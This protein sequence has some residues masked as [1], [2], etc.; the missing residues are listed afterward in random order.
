[1][2][3]SKP[4][5]TASSTGAGPI[6]ESRRPCRQDV[7]VARE[8]SVHFKLTSRSM[9]R[10][11]LY[12]DRIEAVLETSKNSAE[13]VGPCFAR[14]RGRPHERVEAVLEKKYRMKARGKRHLR[15][16]CSRA[17]AER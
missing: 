5:W 14:N 15:G 8:S 1:M 6:I 12:H 17:E 2:T 11:R 3:G 10:Q 9:A 7:E 4:A 13:L 16:K